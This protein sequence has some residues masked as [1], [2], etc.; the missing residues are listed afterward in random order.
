MK[1]VHGDGWGGWSRATCGIYST[2]ELMSKAKPA[3][4]ECGQGRA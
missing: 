4:K 1:T 3:A 2:N